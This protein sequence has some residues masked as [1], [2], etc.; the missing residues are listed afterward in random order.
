MPKDQ[1][2][3]LVGYC[4]FML[5]FT[6]LLQHSVRLHGLLEPLAAL[7]GSALPLAISVFAIRNG[8]AIGRTRLIDRDESPISFWLLVALGLMLGAYLM[9]QGI[10][11]L[12]ALA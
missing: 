11:G 5:A 2:K 9:Y 3:I 7:F 8:W 1:I 10:R 12:A 6:Q 4:I